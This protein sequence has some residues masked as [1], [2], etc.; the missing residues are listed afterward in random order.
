M[1]VHFF[2]GVAVG[3]TATL[4]SLAIAIIFFSCDEDFYE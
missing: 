3:C 4:L 1:M 2:A